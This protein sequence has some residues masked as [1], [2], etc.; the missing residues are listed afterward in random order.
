MKT[1]RKLLKRTPEKQKR[2]TFLGGK[3]RRCKGVGSPELIYDFH[4][5]SIKIPTGI[6]MELDEQILKL[7]WKRKYATAKKTL[8]KN[9]KRKSVLPAVW[10]QNPLKLSYLKTR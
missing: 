5:T 6:F 8:Q 1:E 2:A 3:T 9:R 4:A 10:K 7:I